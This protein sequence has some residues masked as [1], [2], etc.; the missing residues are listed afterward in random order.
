MMAAADDPPP[1][2]SPSDIE[3]YARYAEGVDPRRYFDSQLQEVQ[4]AARK[5]WPLL[6]AA[7]Y[8][9]ETDTLVR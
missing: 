4:Q 1:I 9:P 6:A 7:L 8:P 5:R 3:A 2:L